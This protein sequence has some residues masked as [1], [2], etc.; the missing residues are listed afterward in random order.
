MHRSV[1]LFGAAVLAGM[2]LLV[3]APAAN[4][5]VD[6]VALLDCVTAGVGEVTTIVDPAAP[7][8]PAELPLV[9]CTAP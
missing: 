5:V 4:A 8:L 2:G 3:G 7:G 1:R 9:G 6:P